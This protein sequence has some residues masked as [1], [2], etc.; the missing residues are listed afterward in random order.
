MKNLILILFCLIF[1]SVTMAQSDSLTKQQE[2]MKKAGFLVGT[3][4]GMGWIMFGQG[5]RETFTN[6]ET[7]QSKING[8]VLL[9]EGVGKNAENKIVHNALATLSFDAEKQI[10]RWRA[11]TM[12]GDSV[13]AVPQI[14]DKKFVWGFPLPQGETRFT[15]TLNEKGNWFEI[16]EFS[17][18]GGKHWFKNFEMELKKVS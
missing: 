8:T 11:F 18:D 15:I 4:Q 16:G 1:S 2:A 6:T 3:W 12:N 7:V 17:P 9:V 13:E 14:S 10:Y 5:K